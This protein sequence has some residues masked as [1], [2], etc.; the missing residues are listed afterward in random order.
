MIRPTDRSEILPGMPARSVRAC[1]RALGR[2]D[3][4]AARVVSQAQGD[5]GGEAAHDEAFDVW[6][7]G[8]YDSVPEEERP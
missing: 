6:P 1:G 4:N 5:G 3:V 8:V 7:Q 2:Y